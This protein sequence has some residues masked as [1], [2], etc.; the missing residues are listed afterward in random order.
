MAVFTVNGH[1]TDN[2]RE[3]IKLV[4][5]VWH[6]HKAPAVEEQLRNA[7]SKAT[8]LDIQ[9][10]QLGVV[11]DIENANAVARAGARPVAANGNAAKVDEK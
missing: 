7:L 3:A 1:E 8:P 10:A 4:E 5:Q 9:R 11:P 2:P 6:E